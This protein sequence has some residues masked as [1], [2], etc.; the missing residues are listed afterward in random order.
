MNKSFD[1]IYVSKYYAYETLINGNISEC[2]RY[3]NELIECGAIPVA[4]DE[5]IKIKELIPEKYDYILSKIKYKEV[6]KFI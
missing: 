2:Y 6:N 5:L 1:K 4:I 3:L